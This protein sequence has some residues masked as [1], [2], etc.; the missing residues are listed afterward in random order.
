M[1]MPVYVKQYATSDF[2]GEPQVHAFESM[3]QL[4]EAINSYAFIPQNCDFSGFDFS[5]RTLQGDKKLNSQEN[6]RV[7]FS[8]SRFEGAN[9][10]SSRLNILARDADFSYAQFDAA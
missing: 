9:F 5:H 3:D 6:G 2:S 7:D 1:S 8:G 4:V 10:S